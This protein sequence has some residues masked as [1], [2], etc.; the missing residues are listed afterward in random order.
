MAAAGS[1]VLTR[2]EFIGF[3]ATAAAGMALS[4]CAT[5]PVSGRSQLMLMSE[6]QEIAQDRAASPHMF[7]ADY[8]AVQDAG[9]N[10]YVSE[11][12]GQLAAHSHRPGMPYSF[13]VLNSPVIDAY[14]FPAGSVGISRALILGMESESELAAVLGHEI[15]HVCARHAAQR[16]TQGMVTTLI[17]AGVSANDQR[18]HEKYAGLAAGL[19]SVGAGAL[20][21]HYS[22]DDEREADRL[23]ME[24]ANRIGENPEGMIRLM[25]LL[26]RTETR[27][28]GLIERMFA[29]HPM[30]TERYQ[31]AQSRARVNYAASLSR[32]FKRDVYMDRTTALRRLKPAVD[33]LQAGTMAMLKG[34]RQEAYGHF[35]Q[36]LQQAPDDYA[37][38]LLMANCCRQLNRADR[39]RS[40]AQRALA[41]Y[42]GEPQA[43]LLTGLLTLEKGDF[44]GAYERFAQYRKALP[45]NPELFF[46]C[47]LCQEKMGRQQEATDEYVRYLQVV[48][49]GENAEHA[50]KTLVAWGAVQS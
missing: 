9:L 29:S 2:R 18:E 49:S 1:S 44:G 27:Q 45:G 24:Y 13:R 25:D 22:R 19:V 17:A 14:T 40:L 42:P 26:R 3:G 6:T 35:E 5:N 50:Y 4:G 8:G 12:G 23:G 36:A 20:Q 28:P 38:L 33:Q 37:G 7:S 10:A 15:G 30:T 11:I 41:V 46:Y 34:G 31:N 21:A 32:D 47:G 16:Y 48:Q 39:A 43:V